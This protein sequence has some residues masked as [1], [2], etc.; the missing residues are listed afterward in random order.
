MGLDAVD[1]QLFRLGQALAGFAD[2]QV[3]D[4][5]Q[6]GG[7]QAAFFP[8]FRLNRADHPGQRRLDVEQ[9]AGDVHQ[10]RIVGLALPLGQ[11]E[12]HRQLVDD[13][14]ARLAET[15]YRQG[16]GDLPQGRQQGL[17][18]RGVLAVA[19]YEQVQAFLDPHQLLAQRAEHRAHRVAVRAG[20]AGAFGIHHGAVGQGFIEAITFF[21]TLHPWS[22]SGDFGNVEQQ[23][24][25]QLIRGRG[26]DAVDTL[27]QQTL[28][29]LVAGFEQTA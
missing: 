12:H 8:A 2:H 10:H 6:V 9:G 21:Q 24:L 11:A 16:I 5:R 15:Q 28:E 26:V 25:E 7:G 1:H 27:D 17:K 23:A 18:V 13:H 4:L 14:F 22:R 29:F 3:M 20:Q 19:A